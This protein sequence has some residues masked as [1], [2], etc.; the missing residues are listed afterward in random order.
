MK[1]Y[2]PVQAIVFKSAFGVDLQ[3]FSDY[4]EQAICGNWCFDTVKFD[5]FLHRVN[6]NETIMDF[7]D[8]KFGS[9]ISK[10]IYDLS[11]GNFNTLN[12]EQH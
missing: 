5:E 6:P 11:Q 4:L 12:Y 7:V 9:S 3:L 2:N 10:L 1:T 8:N